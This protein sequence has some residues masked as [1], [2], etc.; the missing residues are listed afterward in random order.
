MAQSTCRTIGS[1][2]LF[3]FSLLVMVPLASAQVKPEILLYYG[4]GCS[5]CAAVEKYINDNNFNTI[6]SIIYKE[7][8]NNSINA[9]ELA[10]LFTRANIS[11]AQQGVPFAV[12]DGKYYTGDTPIIA[13]LN[14]YRATIDVPTEPKKAVIPPVA[15]DTPT[16]VPPTTE[17]ASEPAPSV[18]AQPETAAGLPPLLNFWTVTSAAVIDAIN[19]CAF[20][21]LI[22]LMG[23]VIA[24]NN[25]RKSLLSGLMFTGAIY[26]S[27]YAMG[28]GLYSACATAGVTTW[29]KI[30]IGVLAIILGLFNLKDAIWYGKGFLMEVPLS[31]R[32][33]MKKIIHS[34]TNPL[35][36]FAV[37]IVV[38][39]FLLPCTSG[40]YIIILGMLG[41]SA[42]FPAAL[43]WLAYYNL[44]F[45]L[46][47]ILIT[48]AVYFGLK[49]EQLE[50]IR[51]RRLRLLHAIAGSILLLLGTYILL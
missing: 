40:P 5:H 28:I 20:A 38:S 47:M 18:P 16:T 35:M 2:C 27:Y 23:T 21:V 45:I 10:A 1:A 7:V 50:A 33:R 8:Y 6:F 3:L 48:I 37:G 36:A 4:Q 46:P 11:S 43:R 49:P 9:Q 32:P 39:L 34:V 24:T 25:R 51:Q 41:T 22:I 44:V 31:W 17:P 15:D 19:P 30:I 42:T 12:I 26:L 14:A 29:I 13:A